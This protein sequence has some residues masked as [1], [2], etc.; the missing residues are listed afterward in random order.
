MR[1]SAFSG[2]VRTKSMLW[3]YHYVVGLEGNL[4]DT[5]FQ[6]F[7]LNRFSV[8]PFPSLGIYSFHALVFKCCVDG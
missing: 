2:D 5:V 8:F 1:L 3:L 6:L 4:K 7:R